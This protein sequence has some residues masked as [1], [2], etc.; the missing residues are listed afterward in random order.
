MTE[1]KHYSV[2][3]IGRLLIVKIYHEKVSNDIAEKESK[4]YEDLR[5]DLQDYY[6]GNP[7]V[8]KVYINQELIVD[9]T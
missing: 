9:K 2:A 7:Y 6:K 5:D 8:K 3:P 4:M 1:D